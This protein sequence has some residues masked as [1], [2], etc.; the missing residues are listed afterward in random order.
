MAFGGG[1]IAQFAGACV[2][3]YCIV[4]SGPLAAILWLDGQGMWGRGILAA[5]S[6]LSGPF[7]TLGLGAWYVYHQPAL[8][9]WVVIP[10]AVGFLGVWVTMFVER[11][12]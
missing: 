7:A 6:M 9:S 12:R 4:G 10:A 5:W 11:R 2:L 1:A 3:C 8:L